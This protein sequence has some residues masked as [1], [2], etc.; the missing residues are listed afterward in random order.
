M[1]YGLP[2][3]VVESLVKHSASDS[4]AHQKT[5]MVLDFYKYF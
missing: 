1:N 5:K 4:N 3:L 2:L